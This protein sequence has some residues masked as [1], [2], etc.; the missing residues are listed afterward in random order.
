MIINR[1]ILRF[2][3]ALAFIAPAVAQAAETPAQRRDQVNAADWNPA[4]DDATDA[5]QS[6]IDSG[7]AVVRVPNLGRPWIVRPI[8][9]RSNLELVLEDGVEITAKEGEFRHKND[10]LIS[11]RHARNIILRGEGNVTLRMHKEQYQAPDYTRSEWRHGIALFGCEDVRIENLTVLK[12]GG[13]G[14]C[15]SGGKEIRGSNRIV[16]RKVVSDGNH[17]QAFTIGSGS[18]ILVE[19][20]V[21]KNTSGT[22]PEAGMD[23][24]PGA[25]DQYVER[26]VVRNC[27]AENNAGPGFFVYLLKLHTEKSRPID[28]TFENCRVVNNQGAAF[29]V[30]AIVERNPSGTITFKD[31]LA[32]NVQGPGIYVYDKSWDRAPVLFEN[33]LLRNVAQGSGGPRVSPELIGKDVMEAVPNAPVVLFLRRPYL[34]TTPGGVVF[35]D[36]RVEDRQVRP[37]LVAASLT[38]ENHP[39]DKVSGI[40]HTTSATPFMETGKAGPDFSLKFQFKP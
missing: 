21:L 2:L 4:A 6:A 23:I 14:I 17:R 15:I 12:S 38:A 1:F 39:W 24:E 31:C 40:I 26:I 18:D 33:C 3:L 28:I 37:A 10:C 35:R 16:V 7:A 27:V 13:D 11:A 8:T 30:G 9:L 19:D 32:E 22:A 36:C 34:T 25:H 5:L 20:C 29:V